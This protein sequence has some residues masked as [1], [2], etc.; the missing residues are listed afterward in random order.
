MAIH[1]PRKDINNKRSNQQSDWEKR[2]AEFKL[3][4]EQI[5]NWRQVL[6]LM[7]ISYATNEILFS[8][9]LIK[10]TVFGIQERIKE[11]NF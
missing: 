2:K 3:T 8:D 4:P 7:G 10:D 1:G 11:T 9:Q 6:V 5:N